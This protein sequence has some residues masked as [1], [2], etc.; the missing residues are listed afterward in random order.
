MYVAALATGADLAVGL[1]T[2]DVVARECPRVR[3]IFK[4]FHAE[5]L[6]RA[7]GPTR[8]VCADGRA[9]AE[10]VRE[11]DRTGERVLIPVHA[12]ATVEGAA[13]PAARF[14]MGLSL[15]RK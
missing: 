5:F 3:Y 11:A 13:E 8:F 7:D 4:D 15:K 10:G 6:R 12:V 9:I 14:S 1:L 2:A